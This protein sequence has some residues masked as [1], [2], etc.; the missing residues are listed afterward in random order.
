M[1]EI[2]GLCRHNDWGRAVIDATADGIETYGVYHRAGDN[3]ELIA[4]FKFYVDAV[5]FVQVRCK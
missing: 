4:E 1:Y 5:M 3:V 2:K